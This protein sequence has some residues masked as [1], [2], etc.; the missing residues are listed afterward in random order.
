MAPPIFL[1][2][3]FAYFNRQGVSD[4]QAIIDDI[5]TR[6]LAHSPAWTKTSAGLYKSPVDAAGRFF[7]VLLTKINAQKLEMRVRDYNSVT[8][9]SREESMTPVMPSSASTPVP[10]EQR[11]RI[12]LRCFSEC[13]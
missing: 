13:I 5:D 8:L 7:D 12:G 2:S 6:L 10:G 9:C 1:S 3:S 11:L 4:V